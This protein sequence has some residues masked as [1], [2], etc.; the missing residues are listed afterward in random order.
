MRTE[1]GKITTQDL[2]QLHE[3]KIK[4]ISDKNGS[5]NLRKK[6][7]NKCNNQMIPFQTIPTEYEEICVSVSPVAS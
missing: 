2:I 7:I 4:L 3:K 5:N 1:Q 6:V